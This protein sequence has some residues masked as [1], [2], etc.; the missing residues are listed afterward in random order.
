MSLSRN[1]FMAQLSVCV[2]ASGCTLGGETQD[3]P[4]DPIAV[5]STTLDRPL[6]T[7]GLSPVDFWAPANQQALRN[8]GAAALQGTG[9]TLVATPLLDTAGGRSIL[10]HVFR[11]ALSD[12]TTVQSVAGYTFAGDFNLAPAWTSRSLTTSE[13]R[14]LT[15]CL[16]D[17]LNGLGASVSILLQGSHPGLVADPDDDPTGY[18]I[19]DTTAFGNIFLG[20][21]KAYVCVDPGI[22]IACGVGFSTYTLQRIC[23]LSPTCGASLLGLCTLICAHDAAGDPTC[24]VPLGSTYPEAI[25]TKLSETAALSLYPVCSFL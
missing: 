19:N 2:L 3:A 20:N 13:Q 11:C 22:Q 6:G 4:L 23:G 1:V 9:G 5:P 14:W 15:A 25:S 21:P 24:T 16:L 12:S 17:H 18:T 7:N 8:L 10:S